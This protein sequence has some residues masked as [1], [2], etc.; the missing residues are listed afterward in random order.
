MTL[1]R[2]LQVNI[3]FCYRACAYCPLDFCAWDPAVLRAYV[4]AMTADIEASASELQDAEIDAVSLEGGCPSLATADGLREVLLAIRQHFPCAPD[5][6]ISL[7]TM[8]GEYSRA[9]MEK[10]RDAGVNH[11][12]IGLQT[13]QRREHELLERPYYYDAITMVDT[14]V[15]TFRPKDLSFDLLT[16]IPG[17]TVESFR[18]SLERTLAYEPEHM[19]VIPLRVEPGTRLHARIAAGSVPAPDPDMAAAC[20]EMADAMLG[21]RGMA[22]YT[23]TDYCLPGHENRYKLGLAKGLECVGIGYRSVSRVDG[24]MWTSGHSLQ[25]YIDHSD[26]ITVIANHVSYLKQE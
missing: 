8:P 1:K 12:I 20:R 23:E 17:Q 18:N 6:Q 19:S 13:A 26:D 10:M 16:G 5:M 15:R 2:I 7:Q 3:P 14:A 4:E 24:V 11:W 21:E 25:E 22:P 9:L